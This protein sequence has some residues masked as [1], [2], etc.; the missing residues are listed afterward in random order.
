VVGLFLRINLVLSGAGD[1]GLGLAA[2]KL[3]VG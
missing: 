2:R 1:I 3:P